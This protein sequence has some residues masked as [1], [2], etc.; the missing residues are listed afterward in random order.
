MIARRCVRGRR[1][2]PAV[3]T[4]RTRYRN[5]QTQDQQRQTEVAALGFEFG[6]DTNFVASL[7]VRDRTPAAPEG[8]GT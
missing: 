3:R 1:A 6:V 2:T 8:T 7:S 5:A 4:L